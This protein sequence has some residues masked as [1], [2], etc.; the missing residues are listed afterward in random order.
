M[1][2]AKK[3]SKEHL[4]FIRM[5]PRDGGS[6]GREAAISRQSGKGR[7]WIRT[8][9]QRC[10]DGEVRLPWVVAPEKEHSHCQPSRRETAREIRAPAL[11][12][13]NF[14]VLTGKKGL[15]KL[16]KAVAHLP[17]AQ[18]RMVWTWRGSWR[19]FC[20]KETK[21]TWQHIERGWYWWCVLQSV[22]TFSLL[23]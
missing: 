20:M 9:R 23:S 4:L 13:C 8:C 3:V 1:E 5:W 22:W 7:E 21:Q 15:G 19:I 6:N 11:V 16:V 18:R 10:S 17:E 14:P 2:Q 12:Y